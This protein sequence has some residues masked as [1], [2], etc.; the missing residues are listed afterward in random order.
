GCSHAGA[1]MGWLLALGTGALW[2]RR[3][4]AGT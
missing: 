3:K 1:T 2:A 4:R